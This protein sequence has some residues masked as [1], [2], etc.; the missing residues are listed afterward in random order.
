[1]KQWSAIVKHLSKHYSVNRLTS[2]DEF[3]ALIR[4]IRCRHAV[5]SSYFGDKAP[6][7]KKQCDFCSDPVATEAKTQAFF[8]SDVGKVPSL[9]LFDDDSDLY[10]GGRRGQEK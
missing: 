8:S 5:F 6:E 2:K 1:M 10:G 4:S 3:E 7:C 9:N